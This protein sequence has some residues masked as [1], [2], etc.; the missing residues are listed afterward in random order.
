M[1]HQPKPAAQMQLALDPL[2]R[3]ELPAD[4][5]RELALALAELLLRAAA[6]QSMERPTA[7]EGE[8]HEH[9]AHH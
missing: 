5:Q 9:E 8:Q 4:Q 7:A 2:R 1:H 3:A 6:Q